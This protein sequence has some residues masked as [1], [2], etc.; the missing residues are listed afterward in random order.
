MTFLPI[1][2]SHVTGPNGELHVYF[3]VYGMRDGTPYEVEIRAP[4]EI[5]FNGARVYTNPPPSL[6]GLLIASMIFFFADTGHV[7]VHELLIT[8]F[9]FLTAPISAHFIAKTFMQAKVSEKDLP[10][11][12][13]E[14]GWSVYED[15]PYGTD[16]EKPES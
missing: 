2:P 14:Y 7:S 6:G 1:T 9:L 11:S 10:P 16:G 13:S 15:P 8:L 12:E 3:E 5:G 4:L